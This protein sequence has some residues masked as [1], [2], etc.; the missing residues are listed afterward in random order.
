MC[1]I[2]GLINYNDNLLN[3]RRII[4]EMTNTLIHRGPDEKGYYYNEHALLGHQ[5]LIVIDPEGG[6]QPMTRQIG[7]FKYTLIYNGELYNTDEI[8]VKLKEKGHYFLSHSDT[9]VLLVSYIE[10]GED[11]VMYLNGIYSFA[12]WEEKTQSLFLARDRLG[13]KPLFYANIDNK[14][15]FASEIKAILKHPQIEPIVNKEGLLDLFSLGPSRSLGCGIF[16]DINEVKPAEYILLTPRTMLKST[17]WTIK[18]HA[19]ED[20]DSTTVEKTREIVENAIK[21][22]LVSDVPLCTF[23]SGGLDSSGISSIASQS[24]KLIGSQLNTYSLDYEGNDLHFKGDYYQ[25]TS[26]NYWVD[27]VT[28]EIESG[29]TRHIINNEDLAYKLYRA[30]EAHDLPGMADIDSSL[31]LF[32]KKVKEKQTVAL[33]GECAD[34]IFGGYPWFKNEE[35]IKYEGFPWN[36]YLDFRKS[37]LSD[38]IKDLPYEDYAHSRY[39]ETINEL[40]FAEKENSLDM[41]IKKLTYLNIKWF[42]LTLLN[43]K[44]RMSMANSLEV[45]V[46]YADHRIIEYTFNVPWKLKYEDNVEKSLLRKALEPY[47]PKEVVYRK[48][49]PY[50]K[51]HNP[52][53]EKKVKTMLLDTISDTTAPIHQLINTSKVEKILSGTLNFEKPWFG[54]LM[55]GPQF[56]AYLIQLNYWL[57]KYKVEIRY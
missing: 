2:A 12:I 43:R 6:K 27:I 1:G 19:H 25:P 10:W 42:M 13:V 31:L 53:Y 16:K 54:Q 47:L 41:N 23:L 18:P 45:R 37:I 33:S 30:V 8:R 34:E 11:C 56:L 22:Q 46:P 5:R 40:D 49:S 26:D 29:H 21:R 39:V 15:I 4:E 24:M 51:T 50:P 9:E 57:E 3:N 17:Y 55:K 14:F 36:K 44:D 28:K 20:D 38:E 7:M 48:K 32:C 35:D 52:M